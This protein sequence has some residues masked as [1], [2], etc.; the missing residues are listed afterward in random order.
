MTARGIGRKK[1]GAA[2]NKRGGRRP[3]SLSSLAKRPRSSQTRAGRYQQR[4]AE[5]RADAPKKPAGKAA[6]TEL[7]PEPAG[8]QPDPKPRKPSRAMLAL[9]KGWP[10]SW[11]DSAQKWIDFFECRLRFVK[12]S[13]A[14]E[15]MRLPQWLEG[16]LRRVFGPLNPDGT[17]T[18]RVF[19]LE[20]ASKNSKSTVVS[21]IG[22]GMLTITGERGSEV[23]C[24]AKNRGQARIVFNATRAMIQQSPFLSERLNVF[25]HSIESKADELS[26]MRPI[27]SDSGTQD[28]LDPVCVIFD[29]LHRIADREIVDTL[30]AKQ[31]SRKSPLEVMITTAGELDPNSIAWEK[32]QYAA[33]VIDGTIVDPSWVA[34]IYTVPADADWKDEKNWALANPNLGVS[35]GLEF[36]RAQ[37]RKATKSPQAEMAFRRFHLNQWVGSETAWLDPAKW[38]ACRQDFSLTDLDGAICCAGLDLSTSRDLTAWVLV[39]PGPDGAF[40]LLPRFFM[41]AELLQ[42]HID[43]D[44]VPYDIWHKQGFLT[45]TSGNVIDYTLIRSVIEADAKRFGLKDAAYDPWGATQLAQELNLSIGKE[46]DRDPDTQVELYPFPQNFKMLS[47]PSKNFEDWIASRKIIHDGNPILRW[48]VNCVTIISDNHGNIKPVKPDRR[49]HGRR[50][51]GVVAAIMG[52]ARAKHHKTN[53]DFNQGESV[54]ETDEMLVL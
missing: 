19:Y 36:L 1:P 51:D 25:R 26:V 44:K 54:Y 12:G 41:P 2:A 7:P 47:E 28:G 13:A 23:Y 22:A 21:G 18:C 30:E 9:M 48:M 49:R 31:A 45:L 5:S 42:E 50:I 14:G 53:M 4:N 15:P 34:A 33:G 40:Y 24:C 52:L 3:V 46:S 6:R 20:V 27:S 16:L 8:P 29:E 10:Q 11:R 32:H 38:D 17:R 35:V 39:F 43:K 37:F